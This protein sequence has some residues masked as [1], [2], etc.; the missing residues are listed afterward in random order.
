VARRPDH[1]QPLTL[2]LLPDVADALVAYLRDGRP[3]TALRHVFVRHR[4]PFEPFVPDNNLAT[5]M[6]GAL[7][8]AGL[9]ARAGR[10][11]L[12][13]L[14]HTLAC[15][16]LSAGCALKTIGDVLGHGSTETTREYATVDL[17]MLRAVAVSE[18]EV[19]A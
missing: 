6:R 13:L 15:R 2:P 17:R 7:Q 14:R 19:G 8:R 5:I 4:A 11:A 12:Y 9:E 10:R 16:L 3:A 18:A 1:D